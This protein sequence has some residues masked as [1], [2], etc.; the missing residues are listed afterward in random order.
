MI[1]EQ[2]QRIWQLEDENEQLSRANASAVVAHS[3]PVAFV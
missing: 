2:S 3:V 1:Q